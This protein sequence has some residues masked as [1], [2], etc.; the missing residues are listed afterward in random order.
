MLLRGQ[1]KTRQVYQRNL[2]RNFKQ[3]TFTKICKVGAVKIFRCQILRTTKK[4]ERKDSKTK[5]V[6][7]IEDQFETEPPVFTID[8][9]RGRNKR[10]FS[11]GKSSFRSPDAPPAE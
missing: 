9:G 2:F 4:P 8:S 1:E 6:D 5:F 3:F 10:P 11:M 7:P